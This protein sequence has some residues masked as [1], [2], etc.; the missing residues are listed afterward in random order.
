MKQ[1]QALKK[2]NRELELEHDETL[3]KDEQGTVNRSLQARLTELFRHNLVGLAN[4]YGQ[5]FKREQYTQ[6][7]DLTL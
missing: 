5:F 2:F 1:H 6:N 7:A 3:Q 4:V